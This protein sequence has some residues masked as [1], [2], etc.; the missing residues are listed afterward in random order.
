MS[1]STIWSKPI[2]LNEGADG[3]PRSWIMLMPYG[4]YEHPDY[5]KL[6]FSETL[7]K[8][9]KANFDQR[10]R[11]IDIALDVDHKASQGDSRATGWIE[12]MDLRGPVGDEPGGLWGC[13]AWT[14]YGAQL[15]HDHV[16]RYFSPEFGTYTDEATGEEY[17]DVIIGGALTNRPFLKVMPSIALSEARNTLESWYKAQRRRGASDQ[18]IAMMLREGRA[19]MAFEDAMQFALTTTLKP[20]GKGAPAKASKVQEYDPDDVSDA[21]AFDD[22]ADSEDDATLDD[23]S[24]AEDD[25]TMDD[26]ADA[27]DDATMDDGG[28]EDS[29]EAGDSGA[30]MASKRSGK[31]MASKGRSKM[32]ESVT[33]RKL[34]EQSRQL[35]ELRYGIYERD[36]TDFV[37]G[38]SEG[39]TFQF[40]VTS[41]AGRCLPKG[42]HLGGQKSLREA[43]I[44][45]TPK[46]AN[47]LKGYL[48][49]DGYKLSEQGRDTLIGLVTVL[50]AERATVDVTRYGGSFDQEARQTLRRGGEKAT[51]GD[52]GGDIVSLAESFARSE[53]KTFSDLDAM[54]K[55]RYMTRAEAE[56]R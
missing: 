52:V 31:K 49:K 5:G 38:L 29:D 13:I 12:S 9:F 19:P 26:S 22:S 28:G 30:P 14:P 27:E 44:K 17:A 53:G 7:L 21:T 25:A 54:T 50:L 35:A 4:H 40:S 45:L 46:A 1:I 10:V 20:K 47:A 37:R 16:Y 42:E 33:S 34:A 11:K 48:L 56:M 3:A 15:L 36:V 32:S 18:Q 39:K 24:D 51:G 43:T 8:K 41:V 2:I 6:F 55:V 23:S